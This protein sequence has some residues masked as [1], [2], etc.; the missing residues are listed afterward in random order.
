MTSSRLI[1]SLPLYGLRLHFHGGGAV[2]GFAGAAWRGLLG[3]AL[4][5]SVCSYAAAPVCVSCPRLNA[6]AYPRLFKSPD[7]ERL[8][9][10][11]LHRWRRKAPD[12][13]LEVR[14]L[15]EEQNFALG[16]WLHALA[17]QDDTQHIGGQPVRLLSAHDPRKGKKLWS[18]D[19][20][21]QALPVA[22]PLSLQ[23]EPPAA[24]R[25]R[26]LSPLISKH[27]RDLLYGALHTRLQ[28]L[29]VHYGNAEVLPRPR[30]PWQARVLEQR[31]VSAPLA[32]RV[33]QGNKWLIEIDQIDPEAWLQ[34]QAGQEFHAGGQAGMGCGLYRIESITP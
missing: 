24:C 34:L 25:V 12:W 6:C 19:K 21:W 16:G 18:A 13:Q 4:T 10:F 1:E 5:R 3:Q 14:W 27:Q 2:R 8:P 7:E 32:K 9:P 26:S 17:Q 28:R 11:W 29:I 31:T 20:G 22:L 15:G 33:L 23:A 30:D